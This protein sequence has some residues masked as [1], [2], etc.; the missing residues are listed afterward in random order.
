MRQLN[1]ILLLFILFPIAATSQETKMQLTEKVAISFPE[2]PDV[3]NMQEIT[4]VYSLKLAD[5]TANFNVV[6]Q[7]LEKGNSLTAELLETAQLEPNFW[8][9]LEASF[10][11][12]LGSETKVL[13]KE[14]KNI[15]SKKVLALVLSTE[16]NGKKLELSSYLF[17]QGVYSINIVHSKR[18]DGASADVKNNFFN[19]IKIEE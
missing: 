6:V 14:M 8:E 17:I 2:K 12:Q 18:A 9:Q 13:S 11:A 5:S 1:T 16:R 7:N 3:R 4:T 10:V 19:S 15:G